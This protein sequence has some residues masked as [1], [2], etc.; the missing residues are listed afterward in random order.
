MDS[1]DDEF[2]GVVFPIEKKR[3]MMHPLEEK[4]IAE[5]MF[6]THIYRLD[7]RIAL[8]E[9]LKRI[10]LKFQLPLNIYIDNFFE[11]ANILELETKEGTF[12][13]TLS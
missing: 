10:F 11:N 3:I 2:D 8:T 12:N 13:L 7:S 9:F 5:L 1:F 4:I 6:L